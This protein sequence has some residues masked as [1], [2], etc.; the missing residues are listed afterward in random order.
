MGLLMVTDYITS[1]P[2]KMLPLITDQRSRL[3]YA[4]LQLA[5]TEINSNAVSVHSNEGGGLHG[6]LALRTIPP[7]EYL[8][9]AGVAFAEPLNPPEQ[10]ILPD[11]PTAA[12]IAEANHLPLAIPAISLE[13]MR[14]DQN[15]D[16]TRLLPAMPITNLTKDKPTAKLTNPSMEVRMA[17][18]TNKIAMGHCI[19]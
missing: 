11:A 1:F 13:N 14:E 3:T 15:W 2:T 16:M 10:P 8:I 12:Q 19:P 9:E 17:A 18:N 6:H 5:Q 4:S 7:D